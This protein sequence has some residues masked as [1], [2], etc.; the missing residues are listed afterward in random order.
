M[1]SVGG[2]EPDHPDGY[3]KGGTYQAGFAHELEVLPS[4]HDHHRPRRHERER[5]DRAKQPLAVLN[6]GSHE[7]VQLDDQPVRVQPSRDDQVGEP[8]EHQQ[9]ER[10]R[11]HEGAHDV[12]M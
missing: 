7:W 4:V 2:H 5:L 12:G 11:G 3:V 10:T 9:G 1:S 6:E 8:D